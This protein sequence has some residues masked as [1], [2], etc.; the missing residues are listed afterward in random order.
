M[1]G[2]QLHV[3]KV[4]QQRRTLVPRCAVGGVHDVVAVLGGDRNDRQLGA[5]E[6]FRQLLQLGL[7]LGETGRVEIDQVDLV[8]R[9]HEVLDTKQFRDAGMP[10]GLTQHPARASTSR[11]ATWAL[12]APVN[13]LRV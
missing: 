11:M 3:L 9:G 10:A 4:F 13:M 6:P 7:D 5:A 12:E 8:H 1:G 2:R